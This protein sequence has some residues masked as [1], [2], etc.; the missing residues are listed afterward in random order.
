LPQLIW[1]C[2]LSLLGSPT[3]PPG[4]STFQKSVIVI[5]VKDFAN[6]INDFFYLKVT[7]LFWNQLVN[8]KDHAHLSLIIANK[9]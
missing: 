8:F 5:F 6:S 9:S 7:F 2:I 4:C 3:L 1:I